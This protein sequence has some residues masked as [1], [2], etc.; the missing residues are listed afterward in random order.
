MRVRPI[1]APTKANA[2]RVKVNT[3]NESATALKAV[4]IVRLVNALNIPT[5]SEG[6]KTIRVPGIDLMP[7]VINIPIAFAL[8]SHEGLTRH[9]PRLAL[10]IVNAPQR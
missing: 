9:A 3:F 8:D 2:V 6:L 4:T 1:L 10:S 5:M 7:R